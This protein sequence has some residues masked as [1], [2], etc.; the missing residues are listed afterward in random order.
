MPDMPTG[1]FWK[2]LKP[3][4]NSFRPDA[5]P[6]VY[7]VPGNYKIP[8]FDA[9]LNAAI[10]NV[11]KNEAEPTPAFSSGSTLITGD[12]NGDT[13]ADFVIQLSGLV[14]LSTGDFLL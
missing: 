8:E 7:Q 4:E 11:R 3:I 13:I 12:V 9:V 14:S 6:E 1:E 2:D 10:T 5:L